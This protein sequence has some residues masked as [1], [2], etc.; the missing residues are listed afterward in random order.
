MPDEVGPIDSGSRA[1]SS[2]DNCLFWLSRIK[3]ADKSA[4][5]CKVEGLGATGMVQ[6][7]NQVICTDETGKKK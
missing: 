6:G 7:I 5:Q 3:N 1:P 4:L 2:R